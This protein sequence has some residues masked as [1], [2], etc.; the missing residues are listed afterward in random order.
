MNQ[1]DY[2]KRLDD[3]A[4]AQRAQVAQWENTVNARFFDPRRAKIL[5]MFDKLDG[6]GKNEAVEWMSKAL[7]KQ[8]EDAK[9]VEMP[10]Q[11]VAL[12]VA[13]GADLG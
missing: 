9:H 13:N 3:N 11:F 6:N 5:A 8:Q 4:A 7:A 12:P 1:D 2:L 10:P